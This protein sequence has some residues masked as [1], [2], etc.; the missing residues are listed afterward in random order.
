[1][2]HFT[3]EQ[4]LAFDRRIK[5]RDRQKVLVIQLQKAFEDYMRA[6]DRQKAKKLER[7]M[8]INDN[9]NFL[10]IFNTKILSG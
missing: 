3:C 6:P 10:I 7:L 1:M 2:G 9:V 5:L 4:N 8:E